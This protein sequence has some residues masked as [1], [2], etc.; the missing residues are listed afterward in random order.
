[1]LPRTRRNV[2]EAPHAPPS[3]GIQLALTGGL[4]QGGGVG[5]EGVLDEVLAVELAQEKR[6]LLVLQLVN[7]RFNVG[8]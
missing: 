4:E 8:G 5:R 7:E 3:V 2:V 1:M 6:D